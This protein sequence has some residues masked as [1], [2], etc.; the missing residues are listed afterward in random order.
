MKQIVKISVDKKLIS[1][2]RKRKKPDQYIETLLQQEALKN[3]FQNLIGKL[4]IGYDLGGFKREDI[5]DRA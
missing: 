4:T 1:S 2:L 5:Y 3:K